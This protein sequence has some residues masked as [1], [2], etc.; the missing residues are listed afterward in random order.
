[1]LIHLVGV[2]ETAH[3]A[4]DTEHIVVGGENLDR[5]SGGCIYA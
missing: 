3:T 1:M 2:G 5:F 4:H